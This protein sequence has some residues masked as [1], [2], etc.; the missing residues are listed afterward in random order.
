[1]ESKK[2]GILSPVLR[3]TFRALGLVLLVSG[4]RPAPSAPWWEVQLGVAVR[5]EYTVK[6]P[7][8]ASA[9]EFTYRARWHGTLEKDG[10]DFILYHVRTDVQGWEIREKVALPDG[11]RVLTEKEAAEMPRL[12]LHYILRQGPDLKF[13]FEVQ[14]IKVPLGPLPERFDLVLPRSKEH[15]E[16]GSVYGVFVSKGSNAVTLGED[17]L[18]KP[19][20]EKS[21]SWE[22]RRT[23][24]TVG[25]NGAVQVAGS[26][27]VTVVVTFVRHS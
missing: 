17:A 26:H 27:K 7:G 24:W 1:M 4:L 20:L 2:P 9:G 23:Q 18:E 3:G 21:F 19:D 22:W 16:E 6:E 15:E 12:S 10:D 11:T 14:G 5:G 13:D 25:E 8:A